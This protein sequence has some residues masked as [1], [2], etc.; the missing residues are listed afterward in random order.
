MLVS[1]SK[2][3]YKKKN[4]LYANLDGASNSAKN[5]T[6]WLQENLKHKKPEPTCTGLLTQPKTTS[7]YCKII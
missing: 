5:N 3:H 1:S 4:L 2:R 6:K 7:N